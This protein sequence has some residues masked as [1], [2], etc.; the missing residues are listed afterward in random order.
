MNKL[1]LSFFR[2]AMTTVALTTMSMVL[3]VYGPVSATNAQ[4]ATDAQG[5][6]T[7]KE[8][9]LKEI[10]R[11]LN[12]YKK[13]RK[14][15]DADVKNSYKE[16][17]SSIYD[18]FAKDIVLADGLKVKVKK[19]SDKIIDHLTETKERVLSTTFSN[20]L[21]VLI[22]KVDEQYELTRLTNVQSAVTSGVESLTSVFD[23]L[24]ATRNNLQSQITKM[25]ECVSGID[26]SGDDTLNVDASTLGC[27]QLSLGGSEALASAE[28]QMSNIDVMLST[29]KSILASSV[30][31]LGSLVSTYGDLLEDIGG[32][33]NLDKV[34]DLGALASDSESLS[35]LMGSFEAITA[36]LAIANSMSQE[37]L[38]NL[39]SLGNFINVGDLSVN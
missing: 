17:N 10:D 25:A 29:I 20:D 32:L 36:Q 4:A 14:K 24:Q 16:S 19:F 6:K 15:L 12:H 2:K 37:A 11:Q 30:T 27:D 3:V 35:G 9:V 1:S 21:T 31:L 23:R 33:D 8:K 5:F 26:N 22:D 38:G 28:F 34:D 7:L 13:N 18:S 39:T